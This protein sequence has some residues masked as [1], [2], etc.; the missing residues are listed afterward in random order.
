[1]DKKTKIYDYFTVTRSS[2]KRQNEEEEVI[3]KTKQETAESKGRKKKIEKKRMTKPGNPE[4]L[5]YLSTEVESDE[6][7]PWMETLVVVAVD[8]LNMFVKFENN[9][10][11]SSS[12]VPKS[13]PLTGMGK[14]NK[15][16][17]DFFLVF[18]G[19][20]WSDND[21]Q[22]GLDLFPW[23]KNLIENFKSAA[24]DVALQKQLAREWL[25]GCSNY[26]K[27]EHY[28]LKWFKNLDAF[29]S[30]FS[31]FG[32][33]MN[34][35]FNDLILTPTVAWGGVP[36]PQ[37]K[38]FKSASIPV[39]QQYVKQLHAKKSIILFLFARTGKKDQDVSERI[40]TDIDIQGFQIDWDSRTTIFSMEPQKANGKQLQMHKIES[41]K[42]MIPGREK[43]ED[44]LLYIE[45]FHL[46][47]HPSLA[48]KRVEEAATAIYQHC[49]KEL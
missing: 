42:V 3:T 16:S 41:F 22:D 37:R 14:I 33:D 29:L 20:S 27:E 49:C 32:I 26:F 45:G 17:C 12:M 19:T 47:G 46:F 34:W 8:I 44:R 11:I 36:E 21:F 23:A 2:S 4:M 40:D 15:L 6:F 13:I 31:K 30:V 10:K 48:M 7:Q 28:C 5:E 43:F 38:I 1:M 25:Q 35:V 39:W 9:K 24:G 18:V